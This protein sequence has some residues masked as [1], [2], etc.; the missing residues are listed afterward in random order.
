M[1]LEGIA[2]AA[3]TAIP[4]ELLYQVPVVYVVKSIPTL[5][6]KDVLEHCRANLPRHKMI[7]AVYFVSALPRTSSGKI[8]RMALTPDAERMCELDTVDLATPRELTAN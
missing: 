8:R 5:S 2:E 3:V 4:D 6:E 1:E 7:R